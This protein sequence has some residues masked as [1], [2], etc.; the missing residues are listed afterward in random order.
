MTYDV[1][2]KLGRLNMLAEFRNPQGWF[3]NKR[4]KR[5]GTEA[6]YTHTQGRVYTDVFSTPNPKLET[7]R[8]GEM[9]RRQETSLPSPKW[10]MGDRKKRPH[11][12]VGKK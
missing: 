12:P 9:G 8:N 3:Q 6:D 10:V 1:R 11:S 5:Y 7:C 2:I 4:D